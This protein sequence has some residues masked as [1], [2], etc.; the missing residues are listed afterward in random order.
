MLVEGRSGELKGEVDR[1]GDGIVD[2]DIGPVAESTA[3]V[4]F[5]PLFVI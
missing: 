1:D 3:T 4:D 2:V 5:F